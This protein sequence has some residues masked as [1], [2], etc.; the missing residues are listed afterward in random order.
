MTEDQDPAQKTEE[1]TQ[2]R[3]EES[4]RK[5]QVATSR[6]V[7][8]WFIILAATLL[9]IMLFPAMLGDIKVTLVKFIA[10][11]HDMV[12]DAG[13][14]HAIVAALLTDIGSTLIVPAIILMALA[15]FGGL[16]QNGP[17]FAPDLIKP[18]LEKISFAKGVKRMFSGRSLMEFTKGILKLAIVATVA[19]MVVMPEFDRLTQIPGYHIT[20]LMAFLWELA[21]RVLIA[22]LSV[23]TVIAGMDMLYQKFEHGKKQ[24]MSRQEVR[25]ELKQTEG[26]PMIRAR[27]R[28]IRTERARQRMMS[29]V[30]DAS[31]VITNPT[32]Y[33]VALKYEQDDMEAPV[34]VAKG[35]DK[36]AERIRDVAEENEVPIVENP[37][38]ARALYAGVKI[39][40]EIPPEH[41]RVVAEI[42]GYVM[43]LKGRY[44]GPRS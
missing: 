43:R 10:S 8:H 27:L 23:M 9:V 29:A 40:Q 17:I 3:I 32:H 2:K 5:G 34:L 44:A 14:V 25:D 39:D 35:V 36:M 18:K 11:P 41:Y 22:V 13:A 31:V 20:Q 30:P 28:Q 6:E 12:V 26:D 19:T 16:I 4:H 7:N 15:L 38:L 1:P 24:R 21:G 42:I 37:P 33:A